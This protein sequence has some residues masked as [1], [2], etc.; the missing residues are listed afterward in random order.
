[1]NLKHL[2]ILAAGLS[3]VLWS[4]SSNNDIPVAK[5]P[6]MLKL[7]A[8][9]LINA[10]STII[11]LADYLVKP[12]QIDSLELDK[13]LIGAISADSTRLVIKP[14]ERDFPKLSVLKIWSKG[15]SY[16]LLLE[17]STKIH[18]RFTFDPK[19]KKYKGCRFPDK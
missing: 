1:M 9:I 5:E 4:C 8:P 12:K 15:F 7:T 13:S 16:S 17:K 19:N 18:Y 14:A 10:D 3:L 6:Q 11:E 2:F